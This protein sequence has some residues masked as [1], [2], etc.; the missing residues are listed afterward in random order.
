[1]WMCTDK[2]LAGIHAMEEEK[3]HMTTVATPPITTARLLGSSE[4]FVGDGERQRA[5]A[6]RNRRNFRQVESNDLC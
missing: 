1:M 5:V 6:L 2:S 4:E 3:E